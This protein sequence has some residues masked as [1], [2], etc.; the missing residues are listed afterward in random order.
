MNNKFVIQNKKTEK[1]LNLDFHDGSEVIYVE[2]FTSAYY[3]KNDKEAILFL[4][5]YSLK[6]ED[7][8]LFKTEIFA[9]PINWTK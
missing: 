1:W 7:H 5:N 3:F 6:A 4:L 8:Q 9:Q 2:R